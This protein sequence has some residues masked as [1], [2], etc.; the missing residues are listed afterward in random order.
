M[1]NISFPRDKQIYSSQERK[2]GLVTSNLYRVLRYLCV[3]VWQ[4]SFDWSV[5]LHNKKRV[6]LDTQSNDT[7]IRSCPYLIKK[8][9]DYTTGQVPNHKVVRVFAGFEGSVENEYETFGLSMFHVKL[10]I[11][12]LKRN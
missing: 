3:Y 11:R 9:V 6:E 1:Y 5:D 8:H 10:Y 7:W 12:Q 2:K 4:Y